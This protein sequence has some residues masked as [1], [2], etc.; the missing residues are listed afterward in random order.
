[1]RLKNLLYSLSFLLISF[2]STSQNTLIPDPNF[3]QA[4]IDLGLDS[5]P[6]NGFV[7]TSNISGES[8][9]DVSGYNISNLAGIEGFTSLTN[10]N[11]SDNQLT[12][13][14]ISNNTN[15][16]ELYCNN[17][18]LATLNV[19]LHSRLKILWCYS[20]QLTSLNVNQNPDL[21]SLRCEENTLTDLNTSNNLKLNVLACQ[22]NQITQ[23]DVSKNINLTYLD[24]SINKLIT[25]DVTKNTDLRVLLC[26]QNQITELDINQNVLL[27]DLSCSF[28]QITEL[29]ASNNTTLINLNCDNNNL[30]RLNIKN[31]NNISSASVD[32]RS[33]PNLDCVV[34]DDP[35]GNHSNWE[36]SSFA[37]YVSSP[38]ECS[39][40]V[41]VD[42]LD[43]V[44]GSNYLLPALV[45]GN[46]FT[47]SG[48]NGINLNVGDTITTSQTIYIYN[49]INCYSN[50]SSFNIL[51]NESDYFIPK[52]F[53]P[54]N[55]GSHDV[56]KVLDSNNII[57][58][59]HI[60][61]RA[62]KLLKSLIPNSQGWNGTYNG[63]L[64]RTDDY[65][66]LITLNSGENIS[67]HF[68]LKR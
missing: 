45:N 2:I 24:C 17:N 9:L 65:W 37:N 13:L 52:Y 39:N 27:S 53:T 50:E 19:T 12:T 64:M 26:L 40:F 57:K 7:T 48:G 38:E 46:Y 58:S 55:D 49:E 16:T 34:V 47:E 56:W 63:Q 11:C 68:T 8:S 44:I 4:L 35:N 6:I 43:D 1:M 25:L 42:T 22:K 23:L 31:G 33:N 51:I 59:I 41:L 3:E 5:A 10:L 54:N 32:F 60:F 30:C 61:N 18:Q 66:Y 20:N 62:G 14:N 21:I 29:D 28:N 15:L 67:G 36:P